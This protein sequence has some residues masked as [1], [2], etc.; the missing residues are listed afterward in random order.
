M[1]HLIANND[2]DDNE[3]WMLFTPDKKVLTAG[4]LQEISYEE[5]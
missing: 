4:P 2:E 1:L 5:S 3:Q